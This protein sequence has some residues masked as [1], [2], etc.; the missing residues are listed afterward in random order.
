MQFSYNWKQEIEH[1]LFS[2]KQPVFHGLIGGRTYHN[3][4]SPEFIINSA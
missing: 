4:F 1:F 2:G 3:P